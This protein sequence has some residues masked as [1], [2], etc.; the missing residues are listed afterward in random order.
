MIINSLPGLFKFN[1]SERM[2]SIS[3]IH[4]GYLFL[5]VFLLVIFWG[6][7]WE[8]LPMLFSFLI[9]LRKSKT[10]EQRS[11]EIRSERKD[12]RR[13]LIWLKVFSNDE[14]FLVPSKHIYSVIDFLRSVHETN[15]IQL[16]KSG[17]SGVF[18]LFFISWLYLIC[19]FSYVGISAWWHLMFFVLLLLG[20]FIFRGIDKILMVAEDHFD[21]VLIA[22]EELEYKRM[23]IDTVTLDFKGK[24]NHEEKSFSFNWGKHGYHLFD[25]YHYH[26]G[27]GEAYIL[28]HWKEQR[29]VKI[30]DKIIVLNFSPSERVENRLFQ[31]LGARAIVIANDH[32]ELMDNLIIKLNELEYGDSINTQNKVL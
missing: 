28:K 24:I 8:L 15:S 1:F 2:L 3:N 25:F 26:P 6:L 11:E 19:N 4:I 10:N 7:I 13:L 9:T 32:D 22:L 31:E 20:A 16:A 27:L 18:Y 30:E 17:F 12:I 21:D 29:N 23:V 14:K 5:Y